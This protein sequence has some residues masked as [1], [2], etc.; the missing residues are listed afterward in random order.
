MY[1]ARERW[2]HL[3]DT[4]RFSLLTED[5]HSWIYRG[6]I[7]PT[8]RLITVEASITDIQ[9]GPLPKII[10]DGYLQVDGLY[11]YKMENFGIQLLPL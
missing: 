4:H 6:Q 5:P 11:I 8:N 2:P 1:I 9:D 7:L 10:A 3:I